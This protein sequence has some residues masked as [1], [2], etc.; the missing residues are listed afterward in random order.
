MRAI[1]LITRHQIH[2]VDVCNFGFARMATGR[3]RLRQSGQAENSSGH[4]ISRWQTRDAE[5]DDMSADGDLSY[6]FYYLLDDGVGSPPWTARSFRN[7]DGSRFNGMRDH[8]DN[9]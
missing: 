3:A 1:G 9:P 5:I 4:A 2:T 7:S 6:E 8:L